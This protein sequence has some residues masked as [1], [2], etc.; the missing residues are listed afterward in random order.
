MRSGV[1]ARRDVRDRIGNGFQQEWEGEKE[2]TLRRDE[3][4][5]QDQVKTRLGVSGG[6]SARENLLATDVQ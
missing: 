3:W 5:R 6:V 2:I 1:E 4:K